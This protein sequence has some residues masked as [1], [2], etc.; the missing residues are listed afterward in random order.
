MKIQD[1]CALD[2]RYKVNLNG[3]LR[4]WERMTDF[5]FRGVTEKNKVLKEL[6]VTF[7]SDYKGPIILTKFEA[8]GLCPH[9]FLPTHYTAEVTY[10]P[11]NG[12][13]A[14]TSKAYMVFRAIVAQPLLMEDIFD[15]FFTE[16]WK[17]V[18]PAELKME[19]R[20]K[21][22]CNFKDSVSR[23]AEVVLVKEKKRK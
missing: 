12:R 16:F 18:Q 9:H 13:V 5:Y 11:A 20:G 14:G 22:E 17:R 4:R 21:Y 2:P 10:T 8:E 6:E 1:Y 7:P 15:E 19:M 3:S 23:E